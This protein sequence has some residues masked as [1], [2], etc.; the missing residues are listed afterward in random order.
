MSGKPV[1]YIEGMHG[2]GDNIHQR[3]I[4]RHFLKSY[5]VWLETSWPTV[6]HDLP[7]HFVARGTTLRTQL[8]NAG[9]ERLLF[10]EKPKSF[11]RRIKIAYT[12]PDAFSCG[13]VF[14]AMV[15]HL[16]L[17][18]EGL[19]FSLPVPDRW[20][21]W[22]RE[23]I[24]PTEKP[25]LFY[26]PL[27]IRKEWNNG[28]LRNPDIGHYAELFASI[29]DRFFV[30]SVAD[31]D[32]VNERIVSRP[33]L[34]DKTFH[35]GELNFPEMAGLVA[36]SSMVFSSP[37]FAIPLARAI[38][39]PAICIFGGYE[40]C[41]S[42]SVGRGEYL[43]IDPIEPCFSFPQKRCNKKINIP[44]ALAKIRNFVDANTP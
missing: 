13:S 21:S 22:A 32:D 39:T 31:I 14:L 12:M 10:D 8:K 30:V 25:V 17:N 3:A 24:G 19:D 18:P 16:G 2:L 29:R 11:S 15:K 7:I 26:R 20:R 28:E 43:G 9:K 23:R 35:K 4:I 42:F 44:V 34:A 33:I 40:N 5:D 37:G 41:S 27:V 38:G 36:E 1:L 6:Y